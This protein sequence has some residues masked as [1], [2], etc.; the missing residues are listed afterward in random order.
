M[1]TKE[2]KLYIY[3]ELSD[4]AKERAL[5]E[6]NDRNLDY[7]FL[8]ENLNQELIELLEENKINGGVDNLYYSLGY[9]QGDGVCFEGNFEYQGVQFYVKHDGQYYHKYSVRIEYDEDEDDENDDLK[10]L[11]K[12]NIFN[13]FKELYKD[14]CDK[15]EKSGYSQ[16]EYEQSEENFIDLCEANEY[17][18][19]ENGEMENI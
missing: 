18:F 8:E 2:I 3:D 17:T 15:I 12:E 16:I 5:N 7:P 1:I 11:S 9:C 4:T 13:E 6:H 14:I 19:R 10:A